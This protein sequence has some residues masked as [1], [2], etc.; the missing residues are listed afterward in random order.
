[1]FGLE[2]PLDSPYEQP[3]C[4]S[5]GRFITQSYHE[6]KMLGDGKDIFRS[7]YCELCLEKKRPKTQQLNLEYP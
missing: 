1:M 7:V 2:D 4:D 6:S 3:R 5:C